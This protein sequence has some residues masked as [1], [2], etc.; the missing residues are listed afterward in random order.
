MSAR[1]YNA[2]RSGSLWRHAEL[3]DRLRRYPVGSSAF[4]N[5]VKRFQRDAGL[6]QDGKLGPRTLAAIKA[7]YPKDPVRDLIDSRKK[8][9][10]I[11][12]IGAWSFRGY[13]SGKGLKKGIKAVQA[14]GHTDVYLTVN[15]NTGRYKRRGGKRVWVQR[16]DFHLFEKAATIKAAIR[17][18]RE[19][20]I[21]PHI[22]SWVM[23]QLRYIAEMGQL[24]DLCNDGGAESLMLD[25]EEPWVHARGIDHKSAARDVAHALKGLD[26]PGGLGVTGIVY[27][28]RKAVGPLA[29]LADYVVPQA[30]STNRYGPDKDQINRPDL[31]PGPMQELA[32]KRWARYGKRIVMGLAAYDQAGAGGM[33]TKAAMK[34]ALD[35]T[36]E[37]KIDTVAYWWLLSIARDRA[38]AAFFRQLAE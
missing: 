11:R 2:S 20:G 1:A 7:A 22:M 3:P 5:Q 16:K 25:V 37:L 21:T 31:Y 36:L 29:E 18:Y 19:A 26:L 14:L 12:S 23:P 17:A 32:V 33:G 8:P 24:V 28:S 10:K 34:A 30:Y 38:T 27:H 6:V 13:L 15:D 4:A 35:T 9:A